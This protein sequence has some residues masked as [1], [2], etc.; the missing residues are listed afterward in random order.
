MVGPRC[1]YPEDGE[2]LRGLTCIPSSTPWEG[3]YG[4][5]TWSYVLQNL[6]NSNILVAIGRDHC[7]FI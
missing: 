1:I 6:Q 4:A 3:L 2:A 5:I 7:L